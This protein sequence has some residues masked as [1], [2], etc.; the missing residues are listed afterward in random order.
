M[1]QPGP[2]A[3]HSY[4]AAALRAGVPASAGELTDRQISKSI[5]SLR[6][7]LNTF[8]GSQ[9]PS[10]T[11][12]QLIADASLVFRYPVLDIIGRSPALGAPGRHGARTEMLGGLM[13]AVLMN[14]KFRARYAPVRASGAAMS[15]LM[16]RIEENSGVAGASTSSDGS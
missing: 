14:T 2:S 6:T 10:P 7:H 8:Y 11:Q 16:R 4:R 15:R 3:V 1:T 5:L 12:E 13:D 9:G